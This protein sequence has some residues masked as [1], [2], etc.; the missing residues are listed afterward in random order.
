MLLGLRLKLFLL[1]SGR[2]FDQIIGHI[3]H[4]LQEKV[5]VLQCI[6]VLIFWNLNI[7]WGL[8]I[9]GNQT[10]IAQV[11]LKYFFLSSAAT[12]KTAPLNCGLHSLHCKMALIF[13][14]SYIQN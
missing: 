10:S 6:T 7:K 4:F 12:V 13:S 1:A 14:I 2:I 3:N 9:N 5:F 8:I 11:H